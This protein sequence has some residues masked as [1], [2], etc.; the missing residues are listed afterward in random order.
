MQTP[1]SGIGQRSPS[2][3]T[4]ETEI[5]KPIVP[6]RKRERKMRIIETHHEPNTRHS[7]PPPDYSLQNR[8]RSISPTPSPTTTHYRSN[9]KKM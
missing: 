9:P 3:E 6:Q 2:P 7:E 4:Y 5:V 8:S 1:D